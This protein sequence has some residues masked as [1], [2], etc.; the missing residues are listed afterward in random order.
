MLLFTLI[1]K[2]KLELGDHVIEFLN[3]RHLSFILHLQLSYR[4][5]QSDDFCFLSFNLSLHGVLQ[6]VMNRFTVHAD[7]LRTYEVFLDRLV[8]GRLFDL[9]RCIP[10]NVGLAS[11]RSIILQTDILD[12]SLLLRA[13]NLLVRGQGAPS[14]FV[15]L[16]VIDAG[17]M[18]QIEETHLALNGIRIPVLLQILAPTSAEGLPMVLLDQ[19]LC[20]TFIH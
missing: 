4:T 17:A 11:S 14:L 7:I 19:S 1:K 6:L 8:F 18:V 5:V 15:F 10:Y 3:F 9:Y 13:L 20:R 16:D 2:F 12:R